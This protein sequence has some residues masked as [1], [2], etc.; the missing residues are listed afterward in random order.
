MFCSITNSM[1]KYGERWLY[2]RNFRSDDSENCL[3]IIDYLSKNTDSLLS[4][5]IAQNIYISSSAF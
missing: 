4:F 2:S 5:V 1:R 3:Q